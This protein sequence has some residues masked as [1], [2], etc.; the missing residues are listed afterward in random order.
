M[1]CYSHPEADAVGVC[2]HCGKA[3]CKVC[4]QSS[5]SNRLV[6]SGDCAMALGKHEGAIELIRTKTLRQNRAGAY[7]CIFA[8]VVFGLFGIPHFFWRGFMPLAVFLVVMA[9]VMFVVAAIL[10]RVSSERL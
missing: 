3:V 10:L 9:V 2:I 8:G 1:K 7:F 6:C 4:A 5:S